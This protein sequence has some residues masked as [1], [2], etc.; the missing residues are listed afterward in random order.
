[1][2]FGIGEHALGATEEAVWEELPQKEVLLGDTVNV[3]VDIQMMS[4]FIKGMCFPQ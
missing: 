1:M 3:A 4:H 2:V